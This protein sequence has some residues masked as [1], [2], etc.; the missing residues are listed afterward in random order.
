MR[1]KQSAVH[2]QRFTLK[3]DHILRV[4]FQGIARAVFASYAR[5]R[6]YLKMQQTAQKLSKQF[7]K[8]C[9]SLWAIVATTLQVL[10]GG[11]VKLLALAERQVDCQTLIP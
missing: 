3:Y 9:Y 5:E 7:G 10:D 4:P 11:P 1:A 6:S 8:D 2:K